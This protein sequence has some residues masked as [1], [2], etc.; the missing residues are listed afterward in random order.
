M[1]DCD[2]EIKCYKL[3]NG[4]NSS[5]LNEDIT[6]LTKNYTKIQVDNIFTNLSKI[7][8]FE[9]IKNFDGFIEHRNVLINILNSLFEHELE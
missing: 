3:E 6:E 8:E 2:T 7:E 9:N 1:S 5:F 4:N